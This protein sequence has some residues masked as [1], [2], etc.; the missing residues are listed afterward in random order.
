MKTPFPLRLGTLLAAFSIAWS[1]KAGVVLDWNN[2]ALGAIQTSSDSAPMAARNLA[3]LQAAIYDAV[4]GIDGGYTTFHVAPTS[5][6]AGASME[7]AAAAAARTVLSQLYPSLGSSFT[8]IYNDQINAIGDSAARTAGINW[9]NDV[10]T[11]ILAWRQSDG[12]ATAPGATPLFPTGTP[13]AP[14]G[15]LGG[16]APTPHSDP[17]LNFINPPLLPGW[18]NVTPFAMSSGSQYRPLAWSGQTALNYL[19]TSQYATDYN[20]VKDF[21]VKVGSL[22]NSDQTQAA[23]F[24][25][26]RLGSVTAAGQWNQVARNLL[27]TS[28]GIVREAVVMAA[29]NVALADASITAWDSKYIYDFWRPIVAIAYGGGDFGNPDYDGNPAT[30]GDQFAGIPG[31]GWEP[32]ID[33][34]STPEFLAEGSTFG[35]AAVYVLKSYFGDVA[36]SLLGDTDGDGLADGTRSW[37]SL[38]AAADDAAMAGIYGGYA[39]LDSVQ[40]GQAAGTSQATVLLSGNFLTVPEPGSFL[41]AGLALALFGRRSRRR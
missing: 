26:D 30:I 35:G 39:F 36:V 34:P 16:W 23:Y 33:T 24:W 27:G 8:T 19:T 37:G 21:G 31:V 10:A 28:S 29:L 6:L 38:T 12:S 32:L 11:Q 41:M 4:N 15:Q 17:A 7:A 18:G 40:R 3:I 1:A 13:Y 25:A 20:Q 2:A 9:G 22:R 5:T 14:S